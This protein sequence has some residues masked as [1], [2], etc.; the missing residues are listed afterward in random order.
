M[1]SFTAVALA[2]VA[3]LV[4]NLHYHVDLPRTRLGFEWFWWLT[5]A[6]MSWVMLLTFLALPAIW[7]LLK[8]TPPRPQAEVFPPLKILATVLKHEETPARSP[9]WLTLL[10]MVMATLLILALAEPV[11]NPRIGTIASGGPLVLV[12]DNGWASGTD[13]PLMDWASKS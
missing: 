1:L 6:S 2:S 13:W 10:R 8:L 12:M 9:W 5:H 7:W 3:W 4:R 11:L